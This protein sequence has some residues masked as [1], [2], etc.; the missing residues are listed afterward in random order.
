MVGPHNKGGKAW[1]KGKTKKSDERILKSATTLKKRYENGEIIGSWFGRHHDEE[2]KNKI[3]ESRKKFLKENPDKHPWKNNSKFKSKPCEVLKAKLKENYIEFVS[4][5]TDK[6][7]IHSYAIDIAFPN[8]KIGIEI[9][10]NQHYNKDMSLKPYYKKRQKYLE[11]NR[12]DYFKFSL[13]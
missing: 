3:S 5:Y 1:N 10:G 11:E 7:W 8:K 13:S 12:L 9:N 6:V 4:E 2:T